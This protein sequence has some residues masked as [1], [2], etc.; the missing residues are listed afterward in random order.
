M[1]PDDVKVLLRTVQ[2]CVRLL[3]RASPSS[4]VMTRTAAI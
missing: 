4:V 1:I 2:D 3:G